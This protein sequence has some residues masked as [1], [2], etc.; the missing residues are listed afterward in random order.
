MVVSIRVQHFRSMR[1]RIHFRNQ[2]RIQGFADHNFEFL[3]QKNLIFWIPKP[4][5][6]YFKSQWR[7]SKLQEKPSAPISE[8][9]AFKTWNLN[10][11]ILIGHFCFCP[12]GYGSGSRQ[13][14]SMRIHS[15]QDPQHYK[16]LTNN[17][18]KYWK[19]NKNTKFRALLLYLFLSSVY[20][21]IKK[22][23]NCALFRNLPVIC[24]KNVLTWRLL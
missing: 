5:F 9:L 19:T 17:V 16:I 4:Q 8:H 21:V 22:I 1:I 7:M 13:P 20:L 10:T 14:K 18:R 24:N 6:I 12:P 23:K 15:D 3:W 2:I 11:L